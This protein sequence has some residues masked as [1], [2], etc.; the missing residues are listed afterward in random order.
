MQVTQWGGLIS[1]IYAAD[2]PGEVLSL[3]L[4]DAAGIVN[5]EKSEIQ[6]L[7]E[8]GVNPLVV[9]NSLDFDR[10]MSLMFYK[11]PDM[12]G[13]VRKELAAR[14]VESREFNKKIIADGIPFDML[15]KRLKDIKVKTIVVWGDT[16]RIF[17]SSSAKVLG[18]KLK[19]SKVFIIRESGHLPMTE[20][21]E[22]SSKYY[23]EFIK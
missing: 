15:E 4:F 7:F 2:Y 12:P 5:R 13:V 1:G 22:E 9:E 18:E 8:K 17:P 16:D 10:L 14:S 3:G 11:V 20:K 6:V 23:M 19:G 21:P